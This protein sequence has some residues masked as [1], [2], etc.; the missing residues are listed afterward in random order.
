MPT[1]QPPNADNGNNGIQIATIASRSGVKR[2]LRLPIMETREL[3]KV[4]CLASA[5]CR[6]VPRPITLGNA[7]FEVVM[8][9]M[10][11]GR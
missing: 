3:G 10:L 4:I 7:R 11:L 2:E 9:S 1:L 5:S 6:P 8:Q